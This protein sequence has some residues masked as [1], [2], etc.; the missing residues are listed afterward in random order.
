[1]NILNVDDF[2]D[3]IDNHQV[4][5]LESNNYDLTE[6][7]FFNDDLNKRLNKLYVLDSNTS[8]VSQDL[9]NDHG[10]QNDVDLRIRSHY[11]TITLNEVKA[12]QTN[13]TE[14]CLQL[15]SISTFVSEMSEQKND[16]AKPKRGRPPISREVKDLEK[17][18]NK[19]NKI[20]SRKYREKKSENEKRLVELDLKLQKDNTI[21]KKKQKSLEMN[22]KIMNEYI[23][24]KQQNFFNSQPFE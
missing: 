15:F 12:V 10:Q 23:E 6:E 18:Q 2:L 19:S 16:V 21:L 14:F 22:I 17:M 4:N 20:A 24:Y 11:Q 13:E 9:S 7:S 3:S 5:I 1:M 8:K